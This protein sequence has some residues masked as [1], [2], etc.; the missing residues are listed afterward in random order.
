MENRCLEVCRCPHF[1]HF[2][3]SQKSENQR[4]FL[5]FSSI[6]RWY[7]RFYYFLKQC[8]FGAVSPNPKAFG[9]ISN[10]CLIFL[11]STSLATNQ[12]DHKNPL[13]I[14]K[15]HNFWSSQTVQ[16]RKIDKFLNWSLW[17]V[18]NEGIWM[19]SCTLRKPFSQ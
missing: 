9:K 1:A 10:I 19:I 18:Q 15:K 2:A 16:I 13:K 14:I 6:L 12:L 4:F 3:D 7:F 17:N 8:I 5:K 11:G